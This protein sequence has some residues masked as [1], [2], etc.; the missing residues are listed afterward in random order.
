MTES[1]AAASYLGEELEL[2]LA[3]RRWKA[4]LAAQIAPYVRGAV[5]E[6][7]GGI[8][9]NLPVLATA[10]VSAWTALEP[11]AMLAARYRE[12]HHATPLRF[13]LVVE[14][15]TLNDVD[16]AR[17]DT[18]LYADVL[19]HIADDRAEVQRAAAALKFGGHLIV[20]VPA[21]QWLFSAMDRKIGHQR[22]YT[23]R[24]LRAL[25]LAP[26]TEVRAR[27]LDCVGIAANLANRLLLK[28]GTPSP[29]QIALWDSLMVPASRIFDP[30][31]GY[32]VGKTALI[33]WRRTG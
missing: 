14:S 9:G 17:A 15:R 22:R 30:L 11:D 24:T 13:P 20:I 29:Q 5:L 1:I 23:L 6:V 12:R 33:I 19:E 10:A 4:T 32:R 28:R 16:S 25:A 31:L 8:G 7:G 2:M 3:A 21:H 18:V 26:L 27:Y